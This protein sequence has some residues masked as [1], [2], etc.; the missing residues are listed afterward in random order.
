MTSH[1]EKIR[2][3]AAHVLAQ[4]VL[5]LYPDAKL[6]IGPTIEMGFYYDFDIDIKITEKDLPKIEEEMHRICKEAQEFNHYT[7]T[8]EQALALTKHLNQ[9]YKQLLIEELN[10][11]E[12]SFYENGPFV[13]LCKGPHIHN[14]KEIKH[15]KLLKVAGAYWRGSEKN[16]MLQRIYGTAFENKEELKKHLVNIEEAKKRDHRH[17]GKQLDLFSFNESIGSGLVLWHPKGTQL[18]ETIEQ[19]WK[20]DHKNE[21]YEFIKTPHVG[22]ACLWETSGHLDFYKESMYG[23][24]I[25][26]EQEHYI[27]PM[28]CPFH[29]MIYKNKNHSYK[30]LPVKY[31]ELGTVYRNERSGV[32]HGLLRARGF[33][34]DDAHIIC[35]KTQ[36]DIEIKK[37]L[38]LCLT[39][40]NRYNFKNIE[41]FLSTKPSEKFVGKNNE[42]KEAEN[43]LKKALESEKVPYKVDKGGG[44]F[45]G[46]KIDLK[47]KDAIGRTWQCSTIQFDF[48]LPT[49]FE[50]TYI[51]EKGIK[52]TP[53]MIH[54]AIFGSVERFIGILIEHYNGEFPF[55]LA[56]IQVQ[57]LNISTDCIPYC[58]KIESI[59]KQ[60]NI[61]VKTDLR[62][63]KISK[64]IKKAI[65]EKTP[66]MFIIGQNEVINEK[67]TI[68]TK[69]EISEITSLKEFIKESKNF[70]KE[71]N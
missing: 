59:L 49:R 18:C 1:L 34:Q 24:S 15:L 68:R 3:S 41:A 31:A 40:L 64:K 9:P 43:A 17:L 55:W 12:Y 42:W 32:L 39:T 37:V 67:V 63:E 45:Y 14:T 30:E 35:R 65:E 62:E 6:G 29:I 52:E 48:N 58:K 47:I 8:K 38:K 50:L 19:K 11:K 22:K 56:P 20:E 23:S 57:I 51:N 2:H 36:I 44:A 4:A 27:K 25:I 54:R 21:D 5:K 71:K 70:D 46:P 60:H 26:E 61:R 10:L 28:N 33:T 16:T 53:Y 69:K 66:Y 13:D 7:K